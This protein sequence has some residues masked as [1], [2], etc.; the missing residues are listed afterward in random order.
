MDTDDIK[1]EL[2]TQRAEIEG[3]IS[4]LENARDYLTD[5]IDALG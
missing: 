2:E 5:A 3:M 1:R 4:S